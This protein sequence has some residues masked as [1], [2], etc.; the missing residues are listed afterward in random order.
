MNIYAW[1]IVLHNLWLQYLAN[2]EKNNQLKLVLKL[3]SKDLLLVA[4]P[5]KKSQWPKSLSCLEFGDVVITRQLS[6]TEY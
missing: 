6:L 5:L 3:E 4:F 2:I 1:L